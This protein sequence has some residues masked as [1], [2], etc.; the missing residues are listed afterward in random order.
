MAAATAA[1]AAPMPIHHRCTPI[2][3]S[4]QTA[5]QPKKLI[6]QP[7]VESLPEPVHSFLQQHGKS[8]TAPMYNAASAKRRCDNLDRI[9]RPKSASVPSRSG[10]TTRSLATAVKNF[11]KPVKK[12][13]IGP[14]KSPEWDSCVDEGECGRVD[15]CAVV[16][17]VGLQ[18]LHEHV[19]LGPRVQLRTDLEVK[20]D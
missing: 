15:A 4:V 2:T 7:P 18:H 6:S 8:I 12:I 5:Q 17:S 13:N 1:L 19:D 16:P 11:A 3:R 10:Q 20:V 9:H 14:S